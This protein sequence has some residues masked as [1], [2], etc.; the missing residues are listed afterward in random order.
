MVEPPIEQ[1][2]AA[3]EARLAALERRLGVEPRPGAPSPLQPAPPPIRA[4]EPRPPVVAR[5]RFELSASTVLGWAGAGALL[6]AAAY[7]VRLAIAEGW[8]TPWIQVSGAALGGAAMIGGSFALRRRDPLYS[9]LLGAGGIAILYVAVYGAHVYHG[10]VGA[11]LAIVAA[12]A[13]AALSLALHAVFREPI[14]VAFALAG[15][16]ATPLLLPRAGGSV[17][18]LALYLAVWNLAYAGYAVWTRSRT[19]YLAAL[20]ASL[21]VFEGVWRDEYGG[22]SWGVAAAFQLGQFLLFAATTVAVAARIGQ[23]MS[24]VVAWAHFPA[25]LLLYGI[26]WAILARHAPEA[27]PW[28]AVGFAAAVY[29]AWAAGRAALGGGTPPAG[30]VPMDWKREAREYPDPTPDSP[31]LTMAHAFAAIVL[32]HAVYLELVAPEWRPLAALAVAAAVAFG[33]AGL[34]VWPW[35]GTAAFLFAAGYGKLMWAWTLDD[36]VVSR[37]ALSLAYPALLYALYA[38]TPRG[39][40]RWALLLAAHAMALAAA[41]WLVG[42]WL[43][44]PDTTVER[45]WLSLAWAAIGLAWLFVA[46]A[47]GDH[48]LARSTLGIFAAF[49][50]KVVFADLD[51][52]GPLVRVGILVVLGLTLYAGGWIY[53][54]V[55]EPVTR[56]RS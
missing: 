30:A 50:L 32:V 21:V 28:V 29:G 45:L 4:S 37:S 56:I 26:E 42:E 20:Y 13:V 24:R 9:S 3:L 34:R 54:R 53:R 52:A 35:I 48:A 49:A 31:A 14:Y 15:S 44:S 5:P 36:P 55:L 1:R 51:Q 39:L 41:A 27:A 46:T 43:G 12:G 22:A 10:L 7:F 47:R 18:D 8:L 6:L 17:L 40:W 2:L 33:P 16:Y 19:T 25:L 11:P 23:G 38:G